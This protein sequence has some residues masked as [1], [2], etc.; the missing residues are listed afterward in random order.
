MMFRGGKCLDVIGP[1]RPLLSETDH[2]IDLAQYWGSS[3][4]FTRWQQI[5]DPLYYQKPFEERAWI[6][7]KGSIHS[8]LICPSIIRKL[9][10]WGPLPS[11]AH[12]HAEYWAEH[13]LHMVTG[14]IV[15]TKIP[16]CKRYDFK[17]GEDSM[18]TSIYIN[19]YKISG[20]ADQ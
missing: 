8:C 15:R 19:Q 11:L 1:L 4:G 14:H 16:E 6:A 17:N 13:T 5:L 2:D 7:T 3:E 20:L 18:G 12:P 9:L 10:S